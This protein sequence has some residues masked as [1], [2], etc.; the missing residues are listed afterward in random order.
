MP[1]NKFNDLQG[2]VW[3]NVKNSDIPLVAQ[4]RAAAACA[5]AASKHGV[6]I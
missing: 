2:F 5:A 6:N 4:E 3:R 1:H